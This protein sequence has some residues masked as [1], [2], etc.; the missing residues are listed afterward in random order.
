MGI[1]NQFGNNDNPQAAKAEG[2]DPVRGSGVV[3]YIVPKLLLARNF[4]DQ[5]GR[6]ERWEEYTRLWRGMWNKKDKN[7]NSERSRIIAPAL[8]QAI[9]MTVAEMTEATFGRKAWFDIDDDVADEKKDDAVKLR[10]TLLE[11]FEL[12]GVSDAVRS[13]Y[14]LGAI[15]GTGISKIDVREKIVNQPT[16]GP[17]GALIEKKTAT[18]VVELQAI[19]P[20]QFLIDPSA[21]KVDDAQYVAHEMLVPRHTVE[22]KQGRGIYRKGHVPPYTG[23]WPSLPKHDGVHEKQNNTDDSVLITEVFARVPAHHIPGA[24]AD[25][26]GRVEAIIVLANEATLLKAVASISLLAYSLP[27]SL[28]SSILNRPLLW[29]RR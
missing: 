11:D 7:R 15:Y 27:L 16:R 17:D 24:K 19:R 2:S 20:D 6:K 1:P 10:D 14:L 23:G 5:D 18:V 29:S 28:S 25:P 21:T 3:G 26:D 13:T 4:R 9:E 22:D 12:N 8:Q